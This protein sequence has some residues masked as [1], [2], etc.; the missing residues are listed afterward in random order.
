M[1]SWKLELADDK[2]LVK[3]NTNYFTYDHNE[4]LWLIKNNF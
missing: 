3:I 2:A 4:C 1:I